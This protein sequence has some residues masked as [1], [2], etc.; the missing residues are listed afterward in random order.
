[1]M[2]AVHRYEGTV[3]QVMGDGI[4]ALFGPPLAHEDHAVRAIGSDLHMDHTAV[5]QTRD[6]AA[7]MEQIADAGATLLTPTTLALAEGFVEVKLLGATSVKGLPA[8]LAVHQAAL[9]QPRVVRAAARAS[10]ARR[11]PDPDEVL[12][13]AVVCGKPTVELAQ[14]SRVF[15]L[16]HVRTLSTAVTGGKGIGIRNQRPTTILRIAI[17]RGAPS[18]ASLVG[19][20]ARADMVANLPRHLRREHVPVRRHRRSLAPVEQ[21]GRAHV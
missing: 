4:M 1:M 20:G 7:R 10:K 3:N 6:L 11:P 17:H 2:E 13:T 8:P 14:G 15:G 9:G 12:S 5:G 19:A 21:I 16:G 18:M